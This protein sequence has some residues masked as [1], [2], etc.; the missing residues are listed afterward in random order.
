MKG[1]RCNCDA[2]LP[3]PLSD[4]GL[5][6][7]MTAL[8][9]TKLNFGGLTFDIQS[10]AFRLGNL[11]CFGRA[12][13]DSAGSCADLKLAGVR[14]SG[15]YNVVRPGEQFYRVVSCDMDQAGLDLPPS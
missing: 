4:T 3:A 6:T 5:L 11:Q 13:P 10:G 1:N 7:N 8:P 12:E 2:N 14:R 9:V 15:V